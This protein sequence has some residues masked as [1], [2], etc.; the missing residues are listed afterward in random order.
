[1]T[2]SFPRGDDPAVLVG[3]ST[4]Y[5]QQE[6][7]LEPILEALAGL[8][9]RALVTTAGQVDID[10]LR[11]PSN[12]TITDVLPHTLVLDKTDVMVTHAG[13]GSVASALSFGVP[14]VCT[15]VSR[16]QPLNAQRVAELGAGLALSETP[17]GE[18]VAAAIEQVLST[19]GY[20]DAAGSLAEASR[21][22][23][24]AAA[25]AAELEALLDR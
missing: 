2:A 6:S 20:R 1:V 4:T 5:Q 11:H 3:L 17:T 14:L 23:G 19:P 25:A 24:G 22:E 9:V 16:D 7:L 12:V 21:N 10:E 13:L 8:T 15:P 18:E